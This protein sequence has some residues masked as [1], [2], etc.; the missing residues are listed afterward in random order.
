MVAL[1]V[2]RA[3]LLTLLWSLFGTL[4][5]QHLGE[6]PP[7]VKRAIMELARAAEKD[8]PRIKEAIANLDYAAA[9]RLAREGLSIMPGNM[10]LL[11]LQA[12]ALLRAGRNAEALAVINE[13][14]DSGRRPHWQ[15]RAALLK[16]RLGSKQESLRLAQQG[17]VKNLLADHLKDEYPEPKSFADVEAYWLF[18]I[19]LQENEAKNREYYFLASQRLKPQPVAL[20]ACLARVLIQL[21]ELS[22]GIQCYDIVIANAKHVGYVKA[23]KR[24]RASAEGQLRKQQAQSAGGIGG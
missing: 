16:F 10:R 20:N 11:G 14:D 13:L 22:K 17:F 7:E 23:A 12:E 5:A 1:M 2:A 18:A 3:L 4:S 21:G 9:D 6:T 24:D 8:V 19:G 15:A